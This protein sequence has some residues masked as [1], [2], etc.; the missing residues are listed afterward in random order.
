MSRLAECKGHLKKLRAKTVKIFPESLRCQRLRSIDP[1]MPLPMYRRSTQDLP[2]N[3]A[4]LLV[5]LKMGH[6]PLQK[7]LH[8]IGKVSSSKYLAFWVQ[9]ETVRHYLLTC[10]AYRT[11]RGQL[12]SV[13]QWAMVNQHIFGKPQSLSTPI[14]ICKHHAAVP[15]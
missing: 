15:K 7:Y 2:Q 4:S 11:Q 6:I 12:E 3:Q 14:S 10:L 8:K 1:S 9:D 13:L 5:Q